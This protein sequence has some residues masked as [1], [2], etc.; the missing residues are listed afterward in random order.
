MDLKT[1]RLVLGVDMS[2]DIVEAES[3]H[4]AL[5]GVLEKQI[6]L[7]S[8]GSPQHDD[9][10]R[11]LAEYDT[12]IRVLRQAHE[13]EQ[14]V[15]FT[16][17]SNDSAG[18]TSIE[19]LY[20]VER[21]RKSGAAPEPEQKQ[22]ERQD[23]VSPQNTPRQEE[24]AEAPEEQQL[25]AS[26]TSAHDSKQTHGLFQQK[27]LIS[28]AAAGLGVI[29]VVAAL[30]VTDG[31]DQQN[32]LE[33]KHG[34]NAPLASSLEIA[35]K[36]IAS[37]QT[38]RAQQ[39]ETSAEPGVQPGVQQQ[40]QIDVSLLS[41]RE[42]WLSAQ[43]ALLDVLVELSA[44][45]ED[46]DYLNE[47]RE[48]QKRRFPLD[49]SPDVQREKLAAYQA[50]TVAAKKRVRDMHATQLASDAKARFLE[51][52]S[53][54]R[55][56]GLDQWPLTA[57]SVDVFAGL[58]SAD[59]DNINTQM[60]NAEQLLS[61][62]HYDAAATAYS[63]LSETLSALQLKQPQVGIDTLFARGKDAI[64]R[65]RLSLPLNDSARFYLREIEKLQQD[66]PQYQQL[67]AL[68]GDAYLRLAGSAQNA[69]EFARANTLLARRAAVVGEADKNQL[70]AKL[71][72]NKR[73]FMQERFKPG[74]VMSEFDGLPVVFVPPG[75]FQMGNPSGGLN[76]FFSGLFG[77][78]EYSV[79]RERPVHEVVIDK[80]FAVAQQEISV[81]LFRRF[82]TETGYVTDAEKKGVSHALLNDREVSV[83]NKNWRH[84]YLGGRAKAREPVIHVSY[85]DANAFAVWLSKKTGA[86]YRLPSESEF[87]YVARQGK[88]LLAPWGDD[89]PDVKQGNFRRAQDKAPS[90][91]V[92][93][94]GKEA[95]QT[96]SGVG[97]GYFG[98][99][100]VGQFSAN[101]FKIN[102]VMG[103]VS[104]WT[105]DCY[106][107][108]YRGKDNAQR[109]RGQ[110]GCDMRVVRG[111]HWASDARDLRASYRLDKSRNYS[112]NTLGFRVVRDIQR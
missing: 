86:N 17:A 27:Y 96:V 62:G 76:R 4:D 5:V 51:Q 71:Q 30:F 83:A 103:N 67:K 77:A 73:R 40:S 61:A 101:D 111:A 47:V 50:F 54:L 59:I 109:A 56:N 31:Q 21:E 7:L 23:S 22:P 102:D 60:T 108:S 55:Q 3:A 13:S 105:S 39:A 6:D 94:T 97:D 2:A 1:A 100:P 52:V 112:A 78:G 44:A 45:T 53:N 42:D 37:D 72:D 49:D 68:I 43:S 107:D 18:P 34:V 20:E 10:Q 24:K 25:E 12:A 74:V 32:V 75:K 14:H 8:V 85:N 81:G 57:A 38:P 92:S 91:W 9:A 36:E 33:D 90:V 110:A 63:E 80:P 41:M 98:P 95:V 19:R 26:T 89:E 35:G 58:T 79:S 88:S 84:N 29:L 46:Q 15:G 70:L 48:Q 16:Q 64:R 11:L 87:E 65:N 104:E 106:F 99:A 82:V 93:A 66:A 69:G 28:I